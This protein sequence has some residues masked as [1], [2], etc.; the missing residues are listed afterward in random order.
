MIC[1]VDCSGR[2][3]LCLC[4]ITVGSVPCCGLLHLEEWVWSRCCLMMGASPL[5]LTRSGSERAHFNH[6]MRQPVLGRRACASHY[7]KLEPR[8]TVCSETCTICLLPTLPTQLTSVFMVSV[9]FSTTEIIVVLVLVNVTLSPSQV[10][11]PLRPH[12]DIFVA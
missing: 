3:L 12:K 6:Y 8:C 4:W 5:I 9:W 1:A 2:V 11:G 10:P 7:W